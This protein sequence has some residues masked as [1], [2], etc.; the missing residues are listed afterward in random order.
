MGERLSIP[1]GVQQGLQQLRPVPGIHQAGQVLAEPVQQFPVTP[2]GQG[3]QLLVAAETPDTAAAEFQHGGS[4][5]NLIGRGQGGFSAFPDGIEKAGGHAVHGLIAGD[6]QRLAQQSGIGKGG[7]GAGKRHLLQRPQR[8]QR[9]C[10][11]PAQQPCIFQ[12]G[13]IC[14]Q[15]FTRCRI[16]EPAHQIHHFPLSVGEKFRQQE[17]DA[18]FL[19]GRGKFIQ[20]FGHPHPSS[21]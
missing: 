21:H 19:K 15:Q 11:K 2:S 13:G 16:G 18:A 10:G 14:A 20:M 3:T 7:A 8:L 9:Q 1:G 12:R 17:G 5:R 4:R 6:A